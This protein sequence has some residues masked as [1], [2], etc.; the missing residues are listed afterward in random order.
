MRISKE[1]GRKKMQTGV[2]TLKEACEDTPRTT[3]FYTLLMDGKK[4]LIK[5][6]EKSL[7]EEF[8]TLYNGFHL[9]GDVETKI[10]ENRDNITVD[11]SEEHDLKDAEIYV[12]KVKE[13]EEF[14]WM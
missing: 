10:Y 12:K 3:G 2:S 13:T 11:W 5:V 8:I 9:D 1:L 4:L 14:E 7:R 6:A